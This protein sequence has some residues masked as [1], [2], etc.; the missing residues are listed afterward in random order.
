LSAP[1]RH[2]T[3]CR[4]CDA[5]DLV[6]VLSLASTPPANA[7]VPAAAIADEQPRFPLDLWF[8]R[9]C[10]H[11]QLL[12]VVDP[13]VLFADYVYVSGTS[14][15]FVAHFERY[16]HDVSARFGLTKGDF[17]VDV[18]SNDGSLLG[19]F[20]R[21]GQRVLGVDPAR[22]IARRASE[23]GIET[24]CDFFS[25][26]VAGRIRDKYG[27]ARVVTA[28]NVFAHAD[29]LHG[30]LEGVRA[31]LAPDGVFVF[32]VSYLA[33]VVEKTLFD[34]IY[35]EH[36]DYH[37]VRPLV[38]FFARHGMQLIEAIR[39][40]SHGGSLHGVAQLASGGRPIGASVTEA[41]E[42]EERMGLDREETFIAFGRRVDA[43]GERLR[44][45]LSRIRAEGKRVAGFGAP[46]KATT[47][48]HHFGLGRETLGFIVDDSPLK[49][50]LFT[51][52][53]H[54]PVVASSAIEERRPDYLLILAWNFAR[55][56][57]EKQR[58]F[59]AAGGRF[60][61]PVPDLEVI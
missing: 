6:K 56:I 22:D 40:D 3:S 4:L 37:S 55:P 23:S 45:L 13:S 19:F 61:I 48:M 54:V 38:P 32:E 2:R 16:A 12:D 41:L 24:L 35:H 28:N 58:R 52:G 47:L 9:E 15:V 14:P 18:G 59:A 31:L 50:G 11:L 42:V 51:P 1:Y 25:P 43:L 60:I 33:D 21:G 8:C 46:A 36:L 29:D 27:A 10:T 26:A 57:I 34:T 7:F 5:R 17:V 39:T 49:Q 44:E 30:V 53:L 20:Q